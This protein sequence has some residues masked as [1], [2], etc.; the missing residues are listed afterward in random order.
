MA[1][2]L[3][4]L[5]ALVAL[6]VV[7]SSGCQP[8]S[9]TGGG[10]HDAA[11]FHD[12]GA[13]EATDAIAAGTLVLKEYPP[14]PSPA[15]QGHYIRLLKERCNVDYQVP[16]L[17]KGVAEADFI[18]EIQGWNEVMTAEIRKR[19]GNDILKQLHEEAE[20]KWKKK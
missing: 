9:S 20:A 16:E 15:W 3:G 4:R 18:Q 5:T 11:T 14:L 1:N 8:T 19:F 13:K 6:V 17:P 7:A 2:V 10:G 12:K